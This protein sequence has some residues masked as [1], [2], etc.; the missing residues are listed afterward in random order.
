MQLPKNSRT[1]SNFQFCS[2]A[3]PKYGNFG[4]ASAFVARRSPWLLIESLLWEFL[5]QR[6]AV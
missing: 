5:K 2:D 6:D 3:T 4:H 1:P